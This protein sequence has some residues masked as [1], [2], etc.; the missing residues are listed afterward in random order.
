MGH[1]IGSSYCVK[2]SGR[3]LVRP[4]LPLTTGGLL[5]SSVGSRGFAFRLVDQQVDRANAG[6][7]IS[8]SLL[9]ATGQKQPKIP[10][11]GRPS[12]RA[13]LR[14]AADF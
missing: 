5:A 4:R 1:V 13:M 9:E 12:A 8:E 7:T 2:G 14:I 11:Y 3:S 6:T 10:A